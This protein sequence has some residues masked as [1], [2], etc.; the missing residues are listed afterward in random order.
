M[1]IF[2]SY[3]SPD[4]IALSLRSR[5]HQVFLDRDDL[6]AGQSY[7]EQIAQ[8]VKKSQ[9]FVFLI[10]P[11]SV[12]EG[13]YAL[14]E[15]KFARR[16]WNVPDGHVLPVMVRKTALEQVPPYLKAVAILEPSGSAAAET[17]AAVGEM[18]EKLG[19][20]WTARLSARRY[21]LSFGVLCLIALVA[22]YFLMGRPTV[23]DCKEEARLR[24]TEGRIATSITFANETDQPI[25]IYW[26]DYDGKRSLF[27]TLE[28]G[29]DLGADT[30]V[31]HPWVVATAS[32]K[33]KAIYMP[34]WRRSEVR[35]LD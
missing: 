18:E 26:L 25:Q 29:Q 33:C 16:K 7:D 15:L 1:D 35:V 11:D 24:S 6:P 21:V 20:G 12:G 13:R 22:A 4:K 31:T 3:A 27:G 10:S 9:I 8:A 32:G 17:S 5:G 19:A 34:A 23:V 2:L 28:R 30:F 14:T